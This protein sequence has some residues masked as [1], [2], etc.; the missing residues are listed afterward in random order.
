MWVND[1]MVSVFSPVAQMRADEYRRVTEVNYLGTVHGTLAALRHMRERDTG[2]IV[3]I[4]SRWRT[5]RSP[6]RARTARQRRRSAGS[7]THSGAS[8]N[9]T[10]ATSTSRWSCCRR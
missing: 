7:P 3:Q 4:G 1:A 2:V 6:S 9:M 5:A 10:G 8:C